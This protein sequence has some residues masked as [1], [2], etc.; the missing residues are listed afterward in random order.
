MKELSLKDELAKLTDLARR[1]RVEAKEISPEDVT[2][3]DW[4]R[5]KCAWG[6]KG[7]GKHLAA[8]PTPHRQRRL[9]ASSP[10]TASASCCA[11]RACRA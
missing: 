4:V 11:S 3:A 8:R 1:E 7:Y 10:S 5:F 9:V 2:V 6:C